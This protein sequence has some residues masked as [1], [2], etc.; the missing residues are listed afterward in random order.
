MLFP[1][2]WIFTKYKTLV[3]KMHA[4]LHIVAVANT[5]FQYLCDIKVVMELVYIM[6]L[7][8]IRNFGFCN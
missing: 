2:E 3:L 8:I 1:T 7:F 4:D 6:P 5:N